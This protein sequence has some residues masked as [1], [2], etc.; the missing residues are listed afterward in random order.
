M[1]LFY[2]LTPHFRLSSN[3]LFAHEMRRVRHAESAKTLIDYS[4]LMLSAICALLLLVW[5]LLTLVSP[6]PTTRD[7]F[8]GVA[9]L[10]VLLPVSLLSVIALDYNCMTNSVGSINSEIRAGRWDLLRLTTLE[11]QQIVAAKYGVAQARAWRTMMLVVALR[12]AAVLV[13][14]GS[15][16]RMAFED[17]QRFSTLDMPLPAFLLLIL[18]AAACALF[19]VIEPFW[20]MRTVTA[21]GLAVSARVGHTVS[22]VVFAVGVLG[23]FWLAQGFVAFALLVIV[24]LTI[25]PLASV[26]VMLMQGVLCS[27]V[28]FVALVGVTIYGFYSVFHTWGIRRALRFTARL[29]LSE[30]T[31]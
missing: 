7:Y 11:S 18:A 31:A 23:A 26:E 17:V 9:F 12:A 15:L 4:I 28:L 6:N 14:G 22:S 16:V 8:G 5:L 30:R 10:S 21:I 24:G 13:A 1:K 19:Y 2:R 3:P 25:A 20:R 29:D 27:P